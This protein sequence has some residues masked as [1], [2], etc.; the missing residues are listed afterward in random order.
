MSVLFLEVEE[1]KRGEEERVIEKQERQKRMKKMG[2]IKNKKKEIDEGVVRRRKEYKWII[3]Q[4]W[5]LC[6]WQH[7]HIP[8]IH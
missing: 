1:G 6:K 3:N 8:R 7:V 2:Q 4:C 5:P